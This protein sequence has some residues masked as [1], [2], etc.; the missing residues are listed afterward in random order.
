M[1]QVAPVLARKFPNLKSIRIE[2][3]YLMNQKDEDFFSELSNLQTLENLESLRLDEFP[4]EHLKS[5]TIPALKRFQ[6]SGSR[7]RANQADLIDFLIRHQSVQELTLFDIPPNPKN[8]EK[9]V[10]VLEFAVENLKNLK[11]LS[12]NE[13]TFSTQLPVSSLIPLIRKHVKPGFVLKGSKISPSTE[14]M[15]RYDNEVVREVEGR[16]Q[17][18]DM[19][20]TV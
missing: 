1:S 7:H 2:N 11:F 16:W 9:S 17:L 10:D 3:Q 15:K 12:I 20:N 8:S 4:S 13:D 5:I 6:C 19:T 18:V 14:I